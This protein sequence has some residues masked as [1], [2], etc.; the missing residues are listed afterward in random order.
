MAWVR[1]R[2]SRLG[3]EGGVAGNSGGTGGSSLPGGGPTAL[4]V[5][6]TGLG[7]RRESRAPKDQCHHWVQ[8]VTGICWRRGF[9]PRR[10]AP[11]DA[12]QRS[13]RGRHRKSSWLPSD[14]A[15]TIS[16]SR[17]ARAMVA[18]KQGGREHA[19]K[20]LGGW[21]HQQRCQAKAKNRLGHKANSLDR[22]C[23]LLAA[24]LSLI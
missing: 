2:R 23:Q 3:Q 10:L 24:T 7:R 6:G 17:S 14:P 1:P 13:G 9:N 12:R 21:P 22:K 19:E 18:A 11:E 5:G 16:M 4:G 15:R 20:R 8:F